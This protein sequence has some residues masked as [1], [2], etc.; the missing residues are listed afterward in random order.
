MCAPGDRAILM[1]Q[2]DGWQLLT[3]E[4]TQQ[5]C[6]YLEYVKSAS[7]CSGQISVATL[8]RRAK[9]KNAHRPVMNISSHL[10]PLAVSVNRFFI[11]FLSWRRDVFRGRRR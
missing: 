7:G 3:L 11:L 2:Q 4:L 10:H 6:S 1:P 5:I 9:R 8:D